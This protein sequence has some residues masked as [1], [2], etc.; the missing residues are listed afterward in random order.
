MKKL[1]LLTL[2]LG[3]VTLSFAQ[4][5]EIVKEGP[6]SGIGPNGSSAVGSTGWLVEDEGQVQKTTDGGNTW[7]VVREAVAGSED[8][9]D[10]DFVDENIGFACAEKGEIYKTTDGGA[11]WAL[12]SDTAYVTDIKALDAVNA[13]VVYFAAEDGVLLKTIDGGATYTQA[14]ST[15]GGEDLDGGIAFS[16]ENNGVVLMDGT[17][18]LSWYTT[19]GGVTWTEV[20]LAAYYPPGTASTRMYD[21]A[22]VPGTSTFVVTGYHYVTLISQDGGATYTRIG[23]LSYGYDRNEI[24]EMVDESTFF[25]AGEYL[26]RTQD[27]GATFD[28]LWTGSGQNFEVVEFYDANIGF[29]A[30]SYGVWK[31]TTDGG[32]TW[33]NV[34][35]WPAMSFWGIGLPEEDKVIITGWGG[36]EITETTDNGETFSYPNNYA[37]GTL[38]HIYECEFMSATDGFIGG[39]SGF[40]SKTTDGGASYSPVENPMFLASNKHI[41]ALYVYD[42]NTIFAG[43]S[44]G[45][46]MKSTDG[47]ATWTDTKVQ[48]KTVYDIFAIDANT[49]ITT[50]SSGVIGYGVFDGDAV[51]TDSLVMDIGSNAMRAVKVQNDVVLIACSGG[52]I[53]RGDVN[54]LAGLA[55]IFV[56]PDGDDFYD[57]VFVDDTLVYAVGEAGKIYKSTDAGE[58]WNAETS[59]TEET[60]QKVKVG[61]NKLWAVGQAGTIIA[62]DMTP[63]VQPVDVTFEVNMSVQILEGNFDPANDALPLKIRSL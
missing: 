32:Q 36:G 49:V 17:A 54:D 21:V 26:A 35:E 14:D 25:I 19:D 22:T 15:F 9:N 8:W 38:G 13:D 6:K 55:E 24:V 39:G 45:Y 33:N 47:G 44:S 63:P 20:S 40:L 31:T 50:E 62:L 37:S 43:G 10:V 4:D 11:T 30:Q 29:V 23:G 41:N 51:V 28:T 56:E 59:P 12:V 34:N 48:S 52:L 58:T 16:D 53:Y 2:I 46:V 1:L 3:I 61:N 5:W 7:S 27:G 57:V 42:E 60:L 18:G